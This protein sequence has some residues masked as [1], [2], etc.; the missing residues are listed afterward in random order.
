M[1]AAVVGRSPLARVL[2]A[3]LAAAAVAACRPAP[4]HAG[5][6]LLL[7]TVDTLRADPLACYGGPP[8]LGTAICSLAE[9]GVRFEWA[10]STASHTLPSV[11]SILTSLYPA[12]HGVRQSASSLLTTDFTSVAEV[13][14]SAG[15][16]TGAVVSNPVLRLPHMDQGFETFDVDMTRRERNRAVEEREAEATTDAA[17]A[18]ISRMRSPWFVWVHYQDPHGPYDP[19]DASPVAD[20]REA[21]R[22]RVGSDHSGWRGIPAYQAL[23]GLRTLPA[24]VERYRGEIAYLDRHFGRLLDG[25]EILGAHP[26]ILLTADHGEAFGEDDYYFAHGH[27]LG[28][29]QIRVPLIW[30]P[31]QAA[32][33][34]VQPRA[35][36]LVDVA[37]TLLQAAGV[38]IPAA[39]VGRP[40]PGAGAGSGAEAAERP[41]FSEHPHRAAVIAGDVYFARDREA[42]P[43]VV[44]DPVSGGRIAPLP[45]R[46]ARLAGAGALPAY[47]SGAGAAARLESLLAAHLRAAPETPGARRTDVPE[48]EREA[49]RALGYLD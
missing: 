22:L 48:S 31:P 2:L 39:F 1:R 9:E 44:L 14:R 3:V 21:R 23:P 8:D 38:E 36:S 20:A 26:G 19:P 41:V 5:P 15:Y 34:S 42:R 45:A 18:L 43:G 40:L 28:L 16:E 24:Y 7:V 47:E 12:Q 46:T 32:A 27:S 17:L 35:V 13:L 6:D 30:R 4:R 25:I 10:F 37:P 29:D 11:A 33:A 49:L